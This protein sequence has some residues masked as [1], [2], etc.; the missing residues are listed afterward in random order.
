MAVTRC[1]PPT[2]TTATST[3]IKIPLTHSFIPKA[4]AKPKEMELACTI[5]PMKPKATMSRIEKMMASTRL[6]SPRL[7]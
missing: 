6:L 2:M 5:Q 7:M 4:F 1:C 3:A